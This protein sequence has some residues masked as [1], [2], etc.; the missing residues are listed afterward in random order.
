MRTAKSTAL[1]IAIVVLL[2]A[3]GHASTAPTQA[4]RGSQPTSSPGSSPRADV[5]APPLVVI[6]MENK[7]RSTI[8]G[9]ATA[10]YMNQLLARGKDF[11]NYNAVT[12]PSLPNYLALA[13]GT[14]AGKDG[15]D[16]IAAGELQHIATVWNQLSDAGITFNVYE[17]SM[18]STC[19]SGTSSGQYQLKHNPAIPFAEV[20]DNA[21]VCARVKPYTTGAPLAQVNFV[22]PNMCNDSHDCSA[23]TGDE[24]LR[25]NVPGMIAQGAQVV[26]TYDEGS[27]STNG[28]GNVY[29]VEMYQGISHS[30]VTA[31]FN[32]YSILAAIEKR[33]GLP[34]L[35]AAAAVTPLPLS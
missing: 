21:A 28:G 7:E 13:S 24:W 4:V 9:N 15:T 1:L 31:T 34:Y 35:G 29:C 27:T 2:A 10:P 20:F 18:L 8:V 5:P 33:F 3:C 26:I 19:Y 23:T 11:V 6:F 30:T 17:E 14:T 16:T 25:A 12:H 32:H 22:A